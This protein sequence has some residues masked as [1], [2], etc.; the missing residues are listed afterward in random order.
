MSICR[1]PISVL[2][3]HADAALRHAGDF[4]VFLTDQLQEAGRHGV[5][6]HVVLT[7]SFLSSGL[8]Q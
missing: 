5:A 1:E 6:Q 2:D 3:A 4:G 8:A 7:P